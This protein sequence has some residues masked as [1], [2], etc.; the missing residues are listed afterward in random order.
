MI[1]W[2]HALPVRKLCNVKCFYA[3]VHYI[4]MLCTVLHIYIKGKGHDTHDAC[5][6]IH[7]ENSQWTHKAHK[8]CMYVHIQ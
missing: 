5:D 6:R 7:H 4:Y 1:Q 8:V 3:A 2:Q